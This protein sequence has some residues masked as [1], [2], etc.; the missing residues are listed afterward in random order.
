VWGGG[1]GGGGGGTGKLLC[2]NNKN[3]ATAERLQQEIRWLDHRR[4]LDRK[5]YC[6]RRKLQR[7]EQVR[8]QAAGRASSNPGREQGKLQSRRR[9]EQAEQVRIQAA[10]RAGSSQGTGR[11]AVL[12][13]GWTR[14]RERI[15]DYCFC[16]VWGAVSWIALSRNVVRTLG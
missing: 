14:C 9:A 16:T 11:L 12:Y 6:P 2:P 8:V 3:G 5:F 4:L 13:P 7:A 10:G 1:E 15:M